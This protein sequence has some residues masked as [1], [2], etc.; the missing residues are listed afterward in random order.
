M[1]SL[2]SFIDKERVA[3]LMCILLN[4][5]Y[6]SCVYLCVWIEL[7]ILF[8]NKLRGSVWSSANQ[9]QAE[10][11]VEPIHLLLKGM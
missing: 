6:K 3:H 10:T 7:N 8:T 2:K 5:A 9:Q 1:V 11:I 4:L